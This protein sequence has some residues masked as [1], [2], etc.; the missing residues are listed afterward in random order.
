[1]MSHHQRSWWTLLIKGIV[2][3]VIGI[4]ALAMP[5]S[6]RDLA[7]KFLGLFVLL[8]GIVATV[9]ALMHRRESDKWIVM[10]IPGLVG[11]IIG[12]LALAV[13]AVI[14]AILIYLIAI[15]ALIHGVSE[16]YGALKFREETKGDW[17]PLVVGITSVIFGILL[18]VNPLTA[19]AVF[20]WLI[21]LLILI[22]GAFWLILA[23]RA[24]SWKNPE[25]KEVKEVETET[26][27]E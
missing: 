7:V 1:M 14:T 26:P 6:M 17:V 23:Y 27:P 4:L 8:V 3:I 9:G 21:G 13:P 16:I 19:G 24:W 22:M 10:L 18:L 12:V 15:W 11:I 2:A 20:T 25:V 5:G